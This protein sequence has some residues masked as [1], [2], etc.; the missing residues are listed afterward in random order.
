MKESVP[1]RVIW[2]CGLQQE[3][4]GTRGLLRAAYGNPS[5]Q[6]GDCGS[7]GW[8]ERGT[9]SYVTYI[10]ICIYM[11]IHKNIYNICI[12]CMPTHYI[13]EKWTEVMPTKL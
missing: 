4:A 11:N 8:G 13:S 12:H 1:R 7:G 9:G 5:G 6:Q 2:S 3:K 10:H